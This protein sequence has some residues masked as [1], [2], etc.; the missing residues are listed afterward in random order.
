[1]WFSE[2][3]NQKQSKTNATTIAVHL[4]KNAFELAVADA[5]RRRMLPCSD[6]LYELLLNAA[7]TARQRRETA[8]EPQYLTAVAPAASV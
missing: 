5:Y 8:T 2:H 1:M 4:A 3:L 7:L 6:R